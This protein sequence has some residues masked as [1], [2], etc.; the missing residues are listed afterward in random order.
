MKTSHFSSYEK[1]EHDTVPVWCAPV[2]R[3]SPR[4]PKKIKKTE[5][6]IINR[7]IQMLWKKEN[8]DE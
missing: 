1:F 8:D 2:S 5:T 6:T 4:T 3:D 7:K